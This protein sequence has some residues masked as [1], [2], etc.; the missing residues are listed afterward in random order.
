MYFQVSNHHDDVGKLTTLIYTNWYT[1]NQ[2]ERVIRFFLKIHSTE[3]KFTISTEICLTL[4]NM[5][6]LSRSFM[7]FFRT[8]D[9]S[10]RRLWQHTCLL[11]LSDLTFIF[12]N[13]KKCNLLPYKRLE[14]TEKTKF[15]RRSQWRHLNSGRIQHVGYL[16]QL[17]RLSAWRTKHLNLDWPGHGMLEKSRVQVPL[18]VLGERQAHAK[19]RGVQTRA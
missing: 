8:L 14:T 13:L 17:S 6:A 11:Y 4:H 1:S 10:G 15:S 2:K 18:P 7:I 3:Q 19:A 16:V 12:R 9:V 5:L